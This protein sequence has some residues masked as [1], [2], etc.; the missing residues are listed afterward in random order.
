[1]DPFLVQKPNRNGAITALPINIIRPKLTIT[2]IGVL[3]N[4]D[5]VVPHVTVDDRWIGSSGMP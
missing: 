4:P 5:G 2:V 3:L 1:M